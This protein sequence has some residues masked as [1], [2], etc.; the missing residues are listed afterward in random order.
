MSFYRYIFKISSP[1][2]L[3][4]VVDMMNKPLYF[5]AFSILST[6]LLKE[7]PP[8]LDSVFMNLL[9]PVAFWRAN[10]IF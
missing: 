3:I 10:L 7:K 1:L 9:E 5:L 4:S 6:I 2:R 8:S